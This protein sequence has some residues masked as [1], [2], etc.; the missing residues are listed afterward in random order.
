[1]RLMRVYIYISL[2][3]PG[4]AR[5]KTW[6]CGHVFAGIAGSNPTVAWTFVSC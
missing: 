4:P 6:A 1:M 2:T 3:I 5:S